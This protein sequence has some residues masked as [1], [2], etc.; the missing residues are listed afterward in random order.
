MQN[1]DPL[2]KRSQAVSYELPLLTGLILI[3]VMVAIRWLVWQ[4]PAMNSPAPPPYTGAH[5]QELRSTVDSVL[6]A[7]SLRRKAVR[8]TRAGVEQWDIALP[9]GMPLPS[10]HLAIKRGLDSLN[11]GIIGAD[12]NP[13]NGTLQLSLGW[14]DSCLLVLRLIGA[15]AGTDVTGRI[16]LIIDDFGSVWGEREEAFLRL[17]IPFTAS[18]IPGTA[19][20]RFV[21]GQ[22]AAGGAEILLH[23]PMEPFNLV[24]RDDGYIIKTGMS[25]SE[26]RNRIAKALQEVPHAAGVNNHMGSKVTSH[27]ATI[28][29]VLQ[30]IHA[31][32]LYFVDSRTASTTVACR[33]AEEIGLPCTERHIFLDSEDSQESIRAMLDALKR[34]AAAHGVAVAIGHCRAATLRVLQEEIP[35]LKQEGFVFSRVSELVSE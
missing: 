3:G 29:E 16:A 4:E 28:M 12:S 7:H 19:R 22:L 13:L 11:A 6:D 18:V 21:A 25:Q 30:E 27:R 8:N 26:I 23:M 14:Q 10:A 35:R 31:R 5:L 9:S 32:G 33:V 1:R 2:Q 15:P 34:R 20:C 24:V 17:G